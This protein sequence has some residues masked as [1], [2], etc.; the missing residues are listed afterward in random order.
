MARSPAVKANLKA[1]GFGAAAVRL[2]A[3]FDVE[4]GAGSIVAL[5]HRAAR[6]GTN[7]NL[8]VRE[9]SAELMLTFVRQTIEDNP[10]H[11]GLKLADDHV[12]V[13]MDTWGYDMAFLGGFLHGM[14][15]FMSAAPR[16]RSVLNGY[17]VSKLQEAYPEA[18][19]AGIEHYDLARKWRRE[20]AR[21]GN[22][23]GFGLLGE[24]KPDDYVTPEN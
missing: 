13:Y 17:K 20:R 15:E 16:L 5:V 14:F 4:R 8:V 21:D 9:T 2:P 19:A 24:A 12:D 1:L 23:C 6:A 10:G 18:W 22:L 3:E 7:A 11:A